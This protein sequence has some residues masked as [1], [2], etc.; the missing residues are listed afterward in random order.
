MAAASPQ[1]VAGMVYRCYGECK[2]LANLP[3]QER[4]QRVEGLVKRVHELN[5]KQSRDALLR[6]NGESH[7][8]LTK[9][10]EMADALPRFAQLIGKAAAATPLLPPAVA[11]KPTNPVIVAPKP[12]SPAVVAPKPFLSEPKWAV[13]D[14][15]IHCIEGCT[16]LSITS[17]NKQGAFVF[18]LNVR[19]KNGFACREFADFQ[20]AKEAAAAFWRSMMQ[21]AAKK[22]VAPLGAPQVAP[23]RAQQP[24]KQL[25]ADMVGSIMKR[26]Q[27]LEAIERQYQR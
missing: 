24:V 12:P 10:D 8:V 22:Q 23:M 27:D 15:G 14:K 5:D 17:H 16:G 11:P 13:R 21:E 18:F 4:L 7:D 1:E 19:V 3:P 26:V 2:A 20:K 6:L 25:P 9:L